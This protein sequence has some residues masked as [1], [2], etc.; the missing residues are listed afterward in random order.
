MDANASAPPRE[1]VYGY[2]DYER[3][4]EQLAL[5][6]KADGFRPDVVIGITSGGLMPAVILAKLFDAPLGV[7]AA[8]RYK[9]GAMDSLA[10]HE[11]V[12]VGGHL[13]LIDPPPSGRVL[14]VDDLTDDGATLAACHAWLMR[15]SG[16]R[17]SDLRTAVLWLKTCSSFRPDYAA[18]I[19]EPDER[20]GFPWVIQP[21]EKYEHG[22]FAVIAP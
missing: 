13:A 20:G 11:T 6:I 10:V 3:L 1:L 7:M 5:Q 21:Y 17:V 2:G 16:E 18:M 15:Q 22:G 14:L 9:S 4:I 19:I 12:A 8:R